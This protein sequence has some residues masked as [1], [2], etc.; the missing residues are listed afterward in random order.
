MVALEFGT[1]HTKL[2][3]ALTKMYMPICLR[4]D[5]EKLELSCRLRVDYRQ[6]RIDSIGDISEFTIDGLIVRTCE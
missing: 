3:Q 2:V 4:L 5:W 6:R 1:K